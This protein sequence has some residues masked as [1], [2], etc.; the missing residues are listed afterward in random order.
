MR[1]KLISIVAVVAALAVGVTASQASLTGGSNVK[2]SLPKA[3]GPAKVTIVINNTDNVLVPQRV[4]SVVVTSKAAKWNSKAVPY[5][6]KTVPTNAAGN[7]NGASLRCPK[8]SRVGTGKF[9]VNIGNPGQPIPTD[10]GI[11]N[12]AINVYNYKPKS[13]QQA[14]L[15]FE[16]I[17][18]RP[19]PDTHVYILAGVTKSGVYSAT[20]PNTIDLPPA[21]SNLLR[22]PDMSY[23]TTALASVGVTLKSPPAKKGKRPFLTV[24][25]LKNL[26]FSV[27]LNRD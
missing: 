14:A 19:I 7:N 22:N 9:T 13:G 10:L 17:A 25:N 24:K 23:R 3:G 8:N 5:C 2:V 18:D 4:S 21:V 27:V 6:K 20:I 26:D 16:Q 12:G 11:I 1:I 15:L